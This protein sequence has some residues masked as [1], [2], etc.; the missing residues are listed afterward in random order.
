[1]PRSSFG[2]DGIDFVRRRIAAVIFAG[3][4]QITLAR[5]IVA[6]SVL[7]VRVGFPY[8]VGAGWAWVGAVYA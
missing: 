3:P 1:M 2:W 8:V 6:L 7:R 4:L 5:N